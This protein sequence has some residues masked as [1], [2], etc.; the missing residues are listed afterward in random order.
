M[1]AKLEQS[2]IKIIS[3][4]KDKVLNL[5]DVVIKYLQEGNTRLDIKC[6]YLEKKVVSLEAKLSYRD[7]YGKGNNINVTR[8]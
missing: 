7:Q 4:L 6:N 2:I 3:E 1:L 8:Y 5:K